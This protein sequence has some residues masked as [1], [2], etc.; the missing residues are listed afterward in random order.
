MVKRIPSTYTP[1]EK[2][3]KAICDESAWE[4]QRGNGK[5]QYIYI[6]EYLF[7]VCRFCSMVSFSTSRAMRIRLKNVTIC[8]SA[9]TNG[10]WNGFHIF[11]DKFLAVDVVIVVVVVGG[12]L[13]AWHTHTQII[14]CV[15]FMWIVCML[16]YVCRR[17]IASIVLHR[18]ENS[19]LGLVIM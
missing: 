14:L 12:Y 15:D 1:F 7:Y 17:F 13:S 9:F 8:V 5:R 6:F 18:F 10:M 11:W 4:R 19:P 16:V 2:R 3:C